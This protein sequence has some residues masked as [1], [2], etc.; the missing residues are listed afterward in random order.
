MSFPRIETITKPYPAFNLRAGQK[1]TVLRVER[2]PVKVAGQDRKFY[3]LALGQNE[4]LL[5]EEYFH[6][7]E[8]AN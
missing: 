2:R 4:L 7:E 6:E 5:G 1:F 3:V 8:K